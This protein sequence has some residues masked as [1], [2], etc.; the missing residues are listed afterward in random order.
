MRVL[1][2]GASGLL[3]TW[4]LRHRPPD[5]EVLA[6][7]HRSELATGVARSPERVVDVDLTDEVAVARCLE[8]TMPDVIVHLA[9]SQGGRPGIVG[10]TANLVR[11]G[12]PVVYASSDN[13][14]CGDGRPPPETTEPDPII[15]YGRL[16][17]EA[18]SLVATGEGSGIVRLPLLISFDPVD[19]FSALVLGAGDSTDIPRWYR[20]EY[21]TPALAEDAARAM[22]SITLRSDRAGWW[23]LPGPQRLSRPELAAALAQAAGVAD[24]GRIT[25]GPAADQRPRDL[26]MTADR[27]MRSL[28]WAPRPVGEVTGEVSGPRDGQSRSG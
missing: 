15:D 4:M 3:G 11:R 2:T 13:V 8:Q 19:A 14:F 27:A 16:K 12:C 5:I 26:V 1:L 20:H 10:T 28:G 25:E 6:T 7:R 21:R 23:H 18:E 22:W 24:R 17:A 9:G